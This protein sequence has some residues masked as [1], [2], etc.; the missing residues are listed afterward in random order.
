[1]SVVGS[2]KLSPS[3]GDAAQWQVDVNVPETIVANIE[4]GQEVECQADAFRERVFRG[5][6]T[7]LSDTS[8]PG[9]DEVK[10]AA[11]VQVTDNPELRFKPGMS[12]NVVFIIARR[13]NVLLIPSCA[14]WF[15]LPVGPTDTTRRAFGLSP[16]ELA[17]ADADERAARTVWV[18]RAK[19]EPEPV[20][21]KIGITDGTSTEV[22]AGLEEGD[23][24][25][26]NEVRTDPG[27]Q[28]K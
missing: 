14:L 26:V 15:R 28:A 18:I 9:A 24:V 10:Y 16:R 7:R 6:V 4:V 11:V 13:T 21:T 20:Q 22:L 2:G 5:K 3:A 23:R 1:M 12:V 27:T 25:V 8:E 17:M 19:N